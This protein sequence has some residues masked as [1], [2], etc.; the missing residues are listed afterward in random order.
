MAKRH[1]KRLN[2][3]RTWPINRKGTKWVTRQNPGTHNLEESMPLNIIIRNMLNYAK[4]TKEVKKI[5]NN[6][7]ILIDNI[8]RRDKKF[9][10]G[11][12]DIIEIPKTKEYFLFLLS[13]K[14]KLFLNKI[15]EKHAKVKH[16]K[17][18]NKKKLKKNKLQLNFH[19]GNNLLIEKDNYKVGDTLLI[20]LKDK[21]ILKHLKMEKGAVV[22]LTGGKYKGSIGVLE[23]LPVSNKLKREKAELKRDK[24]NIE[25]LRKYVFVVDKEFIK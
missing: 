2:A 9:P 20:N 3:P 10:V 8:A 18:I 16:L 17:I 6:K 23:K 22:Y 14:G 5:L 7:E 24:K 1:L 4:T 13:E 21:K 19:N 11:V 12:L 15:N 25:T